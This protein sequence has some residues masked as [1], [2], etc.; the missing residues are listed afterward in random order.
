MDIYTPRLGR[1]SEEAFDDSESEFIFTNLANFKKIM[2]I[3][4]SSSLG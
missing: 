4:I 2:T 1:E 3:P